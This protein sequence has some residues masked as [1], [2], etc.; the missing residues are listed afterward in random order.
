MYHPLHWPPL[1]VSFGEVG[2]PEDH[3]RR[4]LSTRSHFQLE[5]QYQKV[6]TKKKATF[7]QKATFNQ[8]TITEGHFQPDQKT[9]TEGHFQPEGHPPEADT[10]PF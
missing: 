3:N 10:P 2:T 6:S 8:K 9:I 5:G 4:P 1:D 7:Y